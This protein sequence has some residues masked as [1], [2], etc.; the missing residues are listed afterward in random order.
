MAPKHDSQSQTQVQSF[1]S[2][3]TLGCA[4]CFCAFV[5]PRSTINTMANGSEK[6]ADYAAIEMEEKRDQEREEA[7][8]KPFDDDFWQKVS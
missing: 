3:V 6:K 8:E 4:W 1:I 7:L 5:C 2:G